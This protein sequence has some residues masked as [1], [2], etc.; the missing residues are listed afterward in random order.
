MNDRIR[1]T[2]PNRPSHGKS[3]SVEPNCIFHKAVLHTHR[4]RLPQHVLFD[5][6]DR[7]LPTVVVSR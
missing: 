5:I 3:N 7:I 6:G 1:E 2:N 4:A